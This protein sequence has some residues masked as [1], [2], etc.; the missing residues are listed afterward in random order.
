[1]DPRETGLHPEEVRKAQAVRIAF[2][3]VESD[4]RSGA[5]TP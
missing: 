5:S 1:M 4:A 2:L 3:V